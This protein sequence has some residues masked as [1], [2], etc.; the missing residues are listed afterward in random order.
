M[1]AFNLNKGNQTAQNRLKLQKERSESDVMAMPDALRVP[2]GRIR[3]NPFQ[4]R[5]DFDSPEAQQSLQEL[6]DDIRKRDILEP[7]IVR[8][9]VEGEKDFYEIIAGERRYRAAQLAGKTTLPV[10]V[11]TNWTDRDARLASLAENLQR[12]NLSLVEEVQF[13]QALEN[14]YNYT[15]KKIS[16]LINKSESY[17]SRRLRLASNPQKLA[18][19][20][21]QGMRLSEMLIT[22]EEPAT[23]V[24]QT[25]AETVTTGA[26]PAVPAPQSSRNRKMKH[27]VRLLPFTRFREAVERLSTQLKDEQL[28]HQEHERLMKE[29][30][31]IAEGI[32]L[33]RSSLHKK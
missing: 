17:V 23:T 6:A 28:N 30:E 22:Q 10:I 12:R 19:M 3:P 16:E 14:E 18:E 11:K 15:A 5:Q 27:S 25:Q 26:D 33:L 21:D 2:I 32:S 4:V 20:S 24:T 29:L 7:L 8:L 1:P 31:L 13:F 9:L